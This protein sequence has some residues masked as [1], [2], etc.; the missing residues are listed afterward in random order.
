[1]VT[2]QL[3][4]DKSRAQLPKCCV[5]QPDNGQCLES[6][7]VT[8]RGSL[9]SVLKDTDTAMPNNFQINVMGISSRNSTL[10][11]QFCFTSLAS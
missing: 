5:H 11:F 3:T 6:T 4:E 2:N 7:T 9:I 8:D 10:L 1:M